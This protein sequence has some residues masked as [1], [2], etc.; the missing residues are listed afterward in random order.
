MG[1][2]LLAL[3]VAGGGAAVVVKGD[4]DPAGLWGAGCMT[5][6][7]V[8]ATGLGV[9]YAVRRRAANAGAVVTNLGV[10]R[11]GI[12]CATPQGVNLLPWE[13]LGGLRIHSIM[14]GQV[15]GATTQTINLDLLGPNQP[16]IGRQA[17]GMEPVH[18]I[19]LSDAVGT[20][21]P[22]AYALAA[23]VGQA[24]HAYSPGLWRG[25]TM[26]SGMGYIEF[27]SWT[28]P[29]RTFRQLA[30]DFQSPTWDNFGGGQ[31]GPPPGPRY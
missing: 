7:F 6:F 8:V 23:D 2:I 28:S 18:R 29:E 3:M 19:H 13:G 4:L 5:V 20:A 27:Q 14:S 24:I 21:S 26:D 9:W 10:A 17:P 30:K 11:N 25:F 31:P 16:V 1:G 15:V 22:V 12:W